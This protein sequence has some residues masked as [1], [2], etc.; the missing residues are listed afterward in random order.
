MCPDEPDIT[1][2]LALDSLD[3]RL[4]RAARLLD[5]SAAL[6]RDLDLDSETN[7]RKIGE[8]LANVFEI[9]NDI[10]EKRPDLMPDHLKP[11]EERP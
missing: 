6:I 4:T 1:E 8:A 7:I 5:Q 9:Q 2:E 10:Y 3:A 11:P